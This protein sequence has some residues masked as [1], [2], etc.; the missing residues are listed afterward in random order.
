M[1]H[2]KYLRHNNC[3]TKGIH[4]N[5]QVIYNDKRSK[6]GIVVENDIPDFMLDLY[7]SESDSIQEVLAYLWTKG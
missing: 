4:C 7:R 6:N 3:C 5:A 1:L 2:F